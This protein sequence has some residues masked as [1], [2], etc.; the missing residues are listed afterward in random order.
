MGILAATYC[1]EESGPQGHQYTPQEF[2]ERYSEYFDDGEKL[3]VLVNNQ[4]Q[5]RIEIPG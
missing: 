4:T 2:V 3:G 1:L 5:P